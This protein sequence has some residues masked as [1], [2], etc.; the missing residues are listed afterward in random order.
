V[1]PQPTG[2]G[3]RE[4]PDEILSWEEKDVRGNRNSSSLSDFISEI[5]CEVIGN[6]NMNNQSMTVCMGKPCHR[7]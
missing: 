4:H 6:L 3:H 2:G 5:V 7:N 1:I